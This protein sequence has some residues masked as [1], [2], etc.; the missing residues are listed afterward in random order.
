MRWSLRST[1]IITVFALALLA[2]NLTETSH[3]V[4]ALSPMTPHILEEVGVG[5]NASNVIAALDAA[6]NAHDSAAALFLFGDTAT[7]SDLSNVACLPGPP[8]FCGGYNVFTTKVQIR[9]WLETLVRE[10]IQVK[11]VG[12]YQVRAGNVTWILQVSLNEYRRLGVAPLVADAQALV[13]NG[14]IE[15]LTIRL[16]QDSTKRLALAY[17]TSQRAPYSILAVG[18][19]FG[20]LVLGLVFP[21]AAVYYI[22]RVERLF[23]SVPGLRKPWVLLQAGVVSLFIAIVLIGIENSINGLTPFLDTIQYVVVVF[24]GFFIFLAMLWMRQ[25]WSV[26]PSD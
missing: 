2:V 22:S 15:S 17:A 12:S 20:I 25:V 10:E 13:Q 8:P 3:H 11:E 16:D 4:S 24:T 1:V 19:G 18:I 7:V 9:G 5:Q 6:F 23:S 14:K 26:A 21:A